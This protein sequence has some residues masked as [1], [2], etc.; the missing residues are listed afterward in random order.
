MLL[1]TYAW[2]VTWLHALSLYQKAVR[3]AINA[4]KQRGEANSD[5]I[6]P[7]EIPEQRFE[8]Y[9]INIYAEEVSVAHDTEP[10][11]QSG[12][13]ATSPESVHTSSVEKIMRLMLGFL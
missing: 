1:W 10:L 5:D 3:T 4:E 12:Y 7:V 8:T 6:I 2:V 11:Y 9:N 13:K